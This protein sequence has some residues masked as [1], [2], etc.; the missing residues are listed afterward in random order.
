MLARSAAIGVAAILAVGCGWGVAGEAEDRPITPADLAALTER[1]RR[2]GSTS[3][4]ITV[5]SRRITRSGRPSRRWRSG[6]LAS[7]AMP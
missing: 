4:G 2:R 5:S 7:S 1:V 3:I 6:T